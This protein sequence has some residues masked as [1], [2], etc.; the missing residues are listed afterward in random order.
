M[1]RALPPQQDTREWELPAQGPLWR[2][3]GPAPTAAMLRVLILALLWRGSLSQLSGFTLTVPQSVSVQEGFCV[4]V[5][6][7]FTYSASYNTYNFWDY[8]PDT[9]LYGYWYKDPAN[10]SQDPPVAS[11]DPSRGV[12]QETQGRFR[13]VGE[14]VHGDCSLLISEAQWRDTGRYFFRFEKGTLRYSYLFNS[15]GTDAKVAISV[16]DPPG[17]P[18]ITWTLTRNGR[19]VPDVWGAEGDVVSLETQEGDSL[20]LSCEVGSRPKGTL[21]WAKGNESLSP[22]QE[23]AGRLELP[24]LSRG[25][26]GEY[27]CWVKNSYGSASRAL[28]VHVQTLEKTLQITVSRANRSDPQ[29]FQDSST[30]VANGSQLSARKGDS[31]RFLCSVASSPPAVLGW[32]RG[33]QIVEGASLEGENQLWL[34]LPNVTV[35]DGGLYG[36]WAQNKQSSAQGTFQLLIEYSPQLG[37]RLNSSCRRQ[38]PSISC[39]CSLRSQPLPQLQWQVDGEPLTGNSS[40]GALQVSSWAQGDEAVSTLNWTGSGVGGPRIFCLGSNPHGSYAVLHFDFRLPQRGAEEPGRLLGLGVAC[41]LGVAVSF[42]LLGLCVI[43]LWGREPALPRAEPGEMANGSQAKLMADDASLIYSNV[44]TI[45]MGHKTPAACRTKG[46]QDEAAAAQAPLGPG[47][48]DEL[49]YAT[50]NFSKLQR[51]LG[52]SPEAPDTEYSEVRLK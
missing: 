36:C 2:P 8:K 32:V 30:L 40:R 37:T 47:E 41:G 43:K 20:S 29:L 7:T 18:N 15:D 26:A 39:S 21:S 3:G 16:P 48:P 46:V 42:F 50:I 9:R 12:S 24:N 49:H 5:P 1:G 14:L 34:E 6:C 19:R 51:K 45:P 25:D 13:L 38:G 31:L 52:E 4:F 11:S 28:R 27:R 17:P 35:E 33:S 44:T 22:G 10:E 23:G